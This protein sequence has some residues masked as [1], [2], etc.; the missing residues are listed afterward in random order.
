MAQLSRLA[1]SLTYLSVGECEPP[2]SLG[3]LSRLQ[4]LSLFPSSDE[5]STLLDDALPQ[6]PQL[7]C[8]VG[9]QPR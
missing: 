9:A 7:T 3:A 8:L 4:H 6:L 2:S 1:G 5:G